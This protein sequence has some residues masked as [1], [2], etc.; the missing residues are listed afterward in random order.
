MDLT[1]FRSGASVVFVTNPV[2][3]VAIGKA[4]G[5]EWRPWNCL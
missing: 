3:G 1:R 2:E 4:L 5:Y